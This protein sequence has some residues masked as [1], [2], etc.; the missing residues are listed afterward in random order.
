M[1]TQP[2]SAASLNDRADFQLKMSFPG[3]VVESNGDIDDSTVSWVFTPGEV[4]DLSAVVAYADPNA[5]SPLN[6]TLLLAVLVAAA[7]GVVVVAARR[8]RN[9]PVSPPIR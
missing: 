9:P 2:A 6:W 8:T 3:S 1:D 5:P 4:G 7:A